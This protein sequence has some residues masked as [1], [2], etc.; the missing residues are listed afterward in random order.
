MIAIVGYNHVASF[1]RRLNHDDSTVVVA[2]R[3]PKVVDVPTDQDVVGFYFY[4]QVAGTIMVD[5]EE[6]QVASAVLHK[7]H[8][9]YFGGCVYSLAQLKD[10]FPHEE[11]LVHNAEVNGCSM[12]MCRDGR[13]RYF[14]E[15]DVLLE[16]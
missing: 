9:Y 15:G 10:K 1:L 13:W 3:D 11:N 5:G 2:A 7:S 16:E 6:I 14:Q 12:I 4:D 8:M